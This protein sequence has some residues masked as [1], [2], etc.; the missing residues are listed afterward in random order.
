MVV[1][2]PAGARGNYETRLEEGHCTTHQKKFLR[3]PERWSRYTLSPSRPVSTRSKVASPSRGREFTVVF[4]RLSRHSSL[5]VAA[6][7]ATAAAA[8]A[9]LLLDVDG[10]GVQ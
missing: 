4:V 10:G 6:D 7:A 1:G 8:V 2:R 9:L 5:R 3:R